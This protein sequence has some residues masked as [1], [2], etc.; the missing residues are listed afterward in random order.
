LVHKEEG[1]FNRQIIHRGDDNTGFDGKRP[2]S[3]SFADKKAPTV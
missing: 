2:T 3:A 1:I